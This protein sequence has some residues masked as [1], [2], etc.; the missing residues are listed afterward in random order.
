[1]II[2]KIDLQKNHIPEFPVCAVKTNALTGVGLDRLREALP[3]FP[4]MTRIRPSLWLEQDMWIVWRTER[5]LEASL[6]EL[7]GEKNLELIAE[8]LRYAS[9]SLGE[10]CGKYTADDLRR[11]F[12]CVLWWK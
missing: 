11:N 6:S 5:Y 7:R 10:I 4:A 3:D 1:M 12:L 8:D 2:S 9:E